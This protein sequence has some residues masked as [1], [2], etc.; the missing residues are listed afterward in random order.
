MSE[1]LNGD[2]PAFARAEAGTEFNTTS[3]AQDGLTKREIFAMA[4][5]QGLVSNPNIIDNKNGQEWISDEAVKYA[6]AL[7]TQ[8]SKQQ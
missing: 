1:I 3:H 4:A 2:L 8:L 5:M 7:L 6:D